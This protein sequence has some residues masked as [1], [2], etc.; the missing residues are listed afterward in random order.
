MISKYADVAMA[1]MDRYIPRGAQAWWSPH[2]SADVAVS[3]VHFARSGSL[4]ADCE[5]ID[6]LR[7][8]Q[9]N[10]MKFMLMKLNERLRKPSSAQQGFEPSREHGS[11]RHHL[12]Q[13]TLLSCQLCSLRVTRR[14]TDAS[15]RLFM[16]KKDDWVVGVGD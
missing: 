7:R 10:L 13:H 1:W 16:G 3:A 6:H 15:S 9:L 11:L 14:L 5:S 2:N 12:P 4:T 8:R